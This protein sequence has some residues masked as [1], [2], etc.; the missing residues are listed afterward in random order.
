L[1]GRGSALT[2]MHTP[3]GGRGTCLNAPS[4]AAFPRLVSEAERI[5]LWV[6]FK[7]G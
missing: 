3:Q 6:K 1:S 2:L 4:E 5:G 7:L